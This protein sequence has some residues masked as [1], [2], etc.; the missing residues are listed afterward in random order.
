MDKIDKHVESLVL[1]AANAKTAD[2]AMK[3]SQ[4]ATNA[5]NAQQTLV[6]TRID[7]RDLNR[8]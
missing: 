6:R 3:F 8:G 4:A 7:E 2:E 5:A 1:K